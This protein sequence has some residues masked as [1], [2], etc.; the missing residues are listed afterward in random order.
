MRNYTLNVS[1]P[2]HVGSESSSVGLVTGRGCL[3]ANFD[4]A[5]IIVP[6]N[7]RASATTTEAATSAASE[8][9]SH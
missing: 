2:P 8:D 5:E 4:R 7:N 3:N 9:V 6:R 1:V